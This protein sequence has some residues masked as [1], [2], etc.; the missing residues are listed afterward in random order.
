[1]HS[2]YWFS[3]ATVRQVAL[4][5]FGGANSLPPFSRV[6]HRHTFWK[7]DHHEVM[8]KDNR[9]ILSLGCIYIQDY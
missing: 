2:R 7:T 3:W 5:R 4:C 9:F 8:S 1:M 6:S